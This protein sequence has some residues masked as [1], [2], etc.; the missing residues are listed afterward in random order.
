[1]AGAN[2]PGQDRKRPD[3]DAAERM[4]KVHEARCHGSVA[5]REAGQG[6]MHRREQLV[7]DLTPGRRPSLYDPAARGRR[8]RPAP[9]TYR[10]THVI[11]LLRA[12]TLCAMAL[13]LVWASR[14]RAHAQNPTN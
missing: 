8:L 13:I 14:A 7:D 12:F 5:D 1:R 2:W 3:K 11:S 6:H 4:T 10:R 9:V